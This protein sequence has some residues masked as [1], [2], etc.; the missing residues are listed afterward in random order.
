MPWRRNLQ[1]FVRPL[2]QAYSRLARGATLGVRG[3]V[4]NAAGEI[5][6]VE[7]TYVPGW[8]LPG[9]GV[10]RG[11]T[12][13]EAVIRELREEGGVQTVGRPKLIGVHANHRVFPGDHVVL[14]RVD[15]WTPCEATSHYEILARGWFRPDDLP[16]GVTRSTRQR[17]EEALGGAEP[18]PHW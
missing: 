9:G 1:P 18:S 10:E 16:A 8:F 4:L 13:E 12:T 7:H 11:E 2:Y 14:Y 3:L 6:L 5:L 15:A 17:I